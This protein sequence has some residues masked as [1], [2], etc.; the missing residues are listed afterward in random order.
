M[1]EEKIPQVKLEQLCTDPNF[2]VNDT[3]VRFG[4]TDFHGQKSED[5]Y[6]SKTG[7]YI[8][9]DNETNSICLQDLP[10]YHDLHL[11]KNSISRLDCMQI[12]QNPDNPPE[13]NILIATRSGCCDGGV[14]GGTYSTEDNS[15]DISFARWVPFNTS[16]IVGNLPFNLPGFA[17]DL[18]QLFVSGAGCA[19]AGIQYL[20]RN[21]ESMDQEFIHNYKKIN[22]D[23]Q[24]KI[25]TDNPSY[26]SLL[27]GKIEVENNTLTVAGINIEEAFKISQ[28]YYQYKELFET[29]QNEEKK[30]S[31]GYTIERIENTLAKIRLAASQSHFITRSSMY[32]VY[33]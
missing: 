3:N 11:K 9:Q 25:R 19:G 27:Y 1:T 7:F 24:G 20:C 23:A 2:K 33:P 12:Q 17:G 5:K 28:Q 32:E 22:Y 15:F 31:H 14:L 8:Q 26:E 21:Y 29:E 4:I 18:T 30:K 16:G 10:I 13:F 6:E